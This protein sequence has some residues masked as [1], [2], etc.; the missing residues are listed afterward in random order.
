MNR[1]A[2][3]LLRTGSV[4][5]TACACADSASTDVT[6][7]TSID[8]KQRIPHRW[9]PRE[10]VVMTGNLAEILQ[11]DLRS[12]FGGL[13]TSQITASGFFR[14]E[15][16]P[17]NRWWLID[18]DGH[19]F[20]SVGLNAV[21]PD[22]TQRGREKMREVFGNTKNWADQTAELLFANAFNSLGAWS[23]HR[24]FRSRDQPI[25]YTEV[26]NFMARYS[27][28]SGQS[29]QGS[30][31]RDYPDSLIPVFDPEFEAFCQEEAKKLADL[32]DDPWLLGYFSDNEMPF[33]E[34]AL[35]RFLARPD[36]D[37]GHIAARKWLDDNHVSAEALTD[38]VRERFLYFMADRYFRISREAIRANDPNHLYLGARFHGQVIR[39]E[40][41]I[42]AA[43]NHVDVLSINWYAQ[44]TPDPETMDNWVAW[45]DKP[46]L[47]TEFFAKAMDSGLPNTSGAG[48]IVKTQADRAA[49]Y[50]NF[51]LPLI[52]HP[53]SVGW[54][55]FRYLDNDPEDTPAD[56]TNIDANKGIVDMHFQPWPELLKA[57]NFIHQRVY[58]L[59]LQR[60][61]AE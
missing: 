26:L 46:F 39:S 29:H 55:W 40:P 30:G 16:D 52:R 1:L 19:P 4:L 28:R 41:V 21:R 42:R 37:P 7:E 27:M 11:P 18:P 12:R 22:R 33:P 5:L 53:S 35:D 23:D 44:W 51:V 50:Q 54:H 32:K 56:P 13:H 49:F 3:L 15:R 45:T 31:H 20:I 57:M 36:T 25:P 38:G 61:A 47:I 24:D 48:W 8:A 17:E 43:G 2:Y 60:T 10:T 34:D 58:Q 14:T 59:R 9:R 6:R